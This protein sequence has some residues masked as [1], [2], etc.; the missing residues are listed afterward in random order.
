MCLRRRD[1]TIDDV[2]DYMTV[3][4]DHLKA[5][6]HENLANTLEAILQALYM[7]Q[8]KLTPDMSDS[9]VVHCHMLAHC[10]LL[11]E[12][13][14]QYSPDEAECV[15]KNLLEGTTDEPVWIDMLSDSIALVIMDRV[16]EVLFPDVH[17]TS[18]VKTGQ[19]QVD[20]L[21]QG[22]SNLSRRWCFCSFFF[23][24]CC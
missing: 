9:E 16:W 21:L 4:V 1:V 20:L 10:A 2:I 13:G 12:S 23:N 8:L 11:R 15:A 6:H 7:A 14:E 24:S 5:D 19:K 17:P 22:L 3:Q 18:H